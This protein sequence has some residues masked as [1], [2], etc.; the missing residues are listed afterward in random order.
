M[1]QVYRLYTMPSATDAFTTGRTETWHL[2][3]DRT[4]NDVDEAR[5]AVIIGNRIHSELHRFLVDLP[6]D[7]RDA[8]VDE[9]CFGP[10]YLHLRRFFLGKPNSEDIIASIEEQGTKVQRYLG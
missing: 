1:T 3:L 5:Q 8:F 9:F 7:E 6:E 10:S 4:Y 2:R